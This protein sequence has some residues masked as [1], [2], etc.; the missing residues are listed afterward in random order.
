MNPHP[1]SILF[2]VNIRHR[3]L[4]DEAAQIRLLR[5]AQANGPTLP[6]AMA[7]ACRQLGATFARARQHLELVKWATALHRRG[8]FSN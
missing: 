5:E 8:V 6:S 4:Q 3:E 2:L 7:T 1:D